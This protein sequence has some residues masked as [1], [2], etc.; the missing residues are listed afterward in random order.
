[1]R[2]KVRLCWPADGG[3]SVAVDATDTVLPLFATRTTIRIRIRERIPILS[4]GCGKFEI[5]DLSV[6]FLMREDIEQGV[7][8]LIGELNLF[9]LR[10]WAGSRGIVDN[11]T[12]AVQGRHDQE[13]RL[14]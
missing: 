7:K 1:M 4:H 9:V 6:G 13:G 5:L 2:V 3:V 14:K 11:S 12:G 8:L 10:R